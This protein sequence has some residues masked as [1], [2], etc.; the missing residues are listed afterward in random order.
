M[1]TANTTTQNRADTSA[2]RQTRRPERIGARGSRGGRC[3]TPG[4]AGSKA[5]TS[6]SATLVTMLTHRICAGVIGM[7]TPRRTAATI[8]IAWPPLVGNAQPT[9]LTRLS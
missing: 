7:V 6:P 9:T 8:A 3:M 2:V 5:N 1:K 4:S